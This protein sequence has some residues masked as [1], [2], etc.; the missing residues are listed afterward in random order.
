MLG[1]VKWI[2]SPVVWES[3]DVSADPHLFRE[4]GPQTQHAGLNG[5]VVGKVG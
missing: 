5:F 4:Q 1:G 3:S 2:S